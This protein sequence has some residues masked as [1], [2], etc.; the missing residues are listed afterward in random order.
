MQVIC[1]IG[2]GKAKSYYIP[3]PPNCP[4]GGTSGLSYL[5]Y[6]RFRAHHSV[7]VLSLVS[8]SCSDLQK[9][10]NTEADT[11]SVYQE[12]LIWE[13]LTIKFLKVIVML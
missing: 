10:K 8:R 9:Y 3:V 4:S 5:I 12:Y 2:P 11:W 1:T 7:T 6:T 13:K